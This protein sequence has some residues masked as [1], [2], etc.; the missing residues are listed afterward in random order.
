[1]VDVLKRLFFMLISARRKEEHLSYCCGRGLPMQT[2]HTYSSRLRDGSSGVAGGSCPLPPLISLS[3]LE[4]LQKVFAIATL[5][6]RGR[7]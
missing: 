1:M 2:R 6:R 4:L 7:Y 5:R 3:S